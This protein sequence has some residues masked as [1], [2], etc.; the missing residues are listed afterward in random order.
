VRPGVRGIAADFG[1]SPGT[2]QKISAALS[3]RGEKAPEAAP[4]I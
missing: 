3:F 2:V 1:V 4:V